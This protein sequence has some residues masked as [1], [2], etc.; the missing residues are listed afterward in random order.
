MNSIEKK[1]MVLPDE[2]IVYPG[3][4]RI[5]MIQDEKN[6]YLELREKDF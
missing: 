4:G 1:L 5:T 3:H 6:I 2:T